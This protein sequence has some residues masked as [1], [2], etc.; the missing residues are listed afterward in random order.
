VALDF[1][2]VCRQAVDA[3]KSCVPEGCALEVG[4]LMGALYHAAGLK[5]RLPQLEECFE[6]P[7]AVRSSQGKVPLSD[8]LKPVFTKLAGLDRNIS[9]EELF[10]VLVASEAGRRDLLR[11]GFGESAVEDVLRVMRPQTAWRVSPDRRDALAALSSFGRMLTEE[12]PP[13]RGRTEL[14]EPLKALV[15]TLSKMKRRNAIIVGFPG[16]G[17]TAL[18]YELARRI[19]TGHPTLPPP[20]RD[21]DLFELSPTFL[22]SGASLV[23][24]YEERVKA[25]IEVL[26][27]HPRIILFIDE[28]HS[29]FQSGVHVR[30]PFSD[31]NESFKGVLGRGEITC[32]GCTTHA[33]YRHHIEPDGALMRRFARIEIRPPSRDTTLRILRERRPRVEAHYAPLRIPEHVLERV[34]KL[35][36]EYLPARFEPDRSIQLID[37]ACAWMTVEQPG[38]VEVTEEAVVEALEHVLGHPI[39]R[40]ERLTEEE[41]Y[42]RLRSKIFGQDRVLHDLGKAFV[43]GLGAWRRTS[44]PRGVYLFGGPTGV[45]KTEVAKHLGRILGGDRDALIRVDCNLLQGSGGDGG[46]VRNLLLGVPAGYV[47]YARGQ[48]GILSR[49]RDLP[50]CVVLFDEFEKADPSVAELLL[51]IIDEGRA[52]DVDGNLLDFRRAYLIFT[53]N[54]GVD[55]GEGGLGFWSEGERTPAVEQSALHDVLRRRLGIGNEFLARLTHTFLFEGLTGE[56][57][58]GIV[59]LQLE[60]LGRMAELRGKSLAWEPGVVRH[61]AHRWQPRFGVRYLTAILRNRILEQLGMAEATGELDAVSRIRLCP[62]DAPDEYLAG[63]SSRRVDGD[64][65]HITIS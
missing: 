2:D 53:T 42:R 50:E 47:G 1:D 63:A 52:E 5:E 40:R 54:A 29:M 13:D 26:T 39:V 19:V 24:Q 9:A 37:H 36:E 57:V 18:V 60:Q 51:G 28:I 22:R 31:A 58:S 41:V 3:A 43:A 33:E 27:A 32:I 12:E 6:R 56:V 14:E 65:L 15:M 35:A 4:V 25:L 48:G 44:G 62:G 59:A 20:L 16:T 11:R 55:Y 46:P 61:L 49:V 7:A 17:K 21:C 38:A 34:V 64:T 45:G 23:G 30:G 10:A 8:E